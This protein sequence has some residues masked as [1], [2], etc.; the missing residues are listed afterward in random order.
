MCVDEISHNSLYIN[1]IDYME[2]THKGSRQ[3]GTRGGNLALT[4]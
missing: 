1:Y 2:C 4:D 3:S